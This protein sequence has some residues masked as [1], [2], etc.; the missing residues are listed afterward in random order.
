[1]KSVIK[2]SILSKAGTFGV[3]CFGFVSVIKLVNA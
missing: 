2:I 3:P 1:M